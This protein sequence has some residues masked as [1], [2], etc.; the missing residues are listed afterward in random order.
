[1]QELFIEEDFNLGTKKDHAVHVEFIETAP[2]NFLKEFY[3]QKC[4]V[5]FRS[6]L[7]EAPF[8]D[9]TYNIFVETLHRWEIFSLV[10]L[11]KN[12][13]KFPLGYADKKVQ[14]ESAAGALYTKSPV[15][16]LRTVFCTFIS[17]GTS[18]SGLKVWW[19]NGSVAQLINRFDG[20]TDRWIVGSMV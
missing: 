12:I 19:F 13:Q 16:S 20:S 15:T 1:M 3:C 14:R 11:N 7:I 8:F 10:M 5:T 17:L 4:G 6:K 9:V 18:L 2:T